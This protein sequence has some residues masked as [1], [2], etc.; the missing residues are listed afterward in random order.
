MT[1]LDRLRYAWF[2]MREAWPDRKTLGWVYTT[3]VC[4]FAVCFALDVP[5]VRCFKCR[6]TWTYWDP[7]VGAY[8]GPCHRKYGRG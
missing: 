8:C 1:F 3:R 2:E 5:G 4:W 6:R 7:I